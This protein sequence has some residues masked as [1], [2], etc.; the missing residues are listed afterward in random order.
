MTCISSSKL[1]DIVTCT[2]YSLHFWHKILQDNPKPC[3]KWTSNHVVSRVGNISWQWRR[4]PRPPHIILFW[5]RLMDLTYI[6]RNRTKL[7]PEFSLASLKDTETTIYAAPSTIKP[8]HYGSWRDYPSLSTL[9]H[10]GVI[11]KKY[12]VVVPKTYH[13]LCVDN[14]NHNL[15]F[16]PPPW[17]WV[18]PM[19]DALGQP[20]ERDGIIP[21][22]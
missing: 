4:I 5:S 8:C 6:C 7:G 11:H 19:L 16:R 2:M 9:V 10:R 21:L 20:L 22:P 14:T 15:S 12:E 18:A 13:V 1:D 3:R 17:Q